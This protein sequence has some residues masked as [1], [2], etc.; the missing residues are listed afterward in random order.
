MN[1]IV[2]GLGFGD[3]GK[4]ITTDYLA[5]KNPDSFVVRFSGGHQAGHTVVVDGK[6]HVFSNF[7]SG[8]FRGIPTY[9]LSSCPIEPMALTHELELLQ[10]KGVQPKLFID[11]NC[12]ITTPFDIEYNRMNSKILSDGSC[13]MGIFSTFKREQENYHLRFQD[14]FNTSVFLIKLNLIKKYYTQVGVPEYF[15]YFLEC[16]E[17]ITESENIKV[18]D[19]TM[20]SINDGGL[21]YEGSQGLLLDK[22]IGFFPHVTPSNTGTKG[23][24][25]KYPSEI[26]LVTRGYQTRHGNG[27]MTNT[28]HNAKI[29]LDK[30]ETNVNNTFQGEFKISVLDLDLLTYGVVKDEFIRNNHFNNL[31]ITCPFNNVSSGQILADSSLQRH[32]ISPLSLIKNTC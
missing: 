1:Q 16:C 31:V 2:I 4:G 25:L 3:E 26:F 5:S 10:I 30:D 21:I 7:G 11:E 23:L 13:G 18:I 6:R 28:S 24:K 15:D 27:P 8:S 19:K 12:P 9:W 17:Y 29:I 14:L 20:L 22:D 32:T